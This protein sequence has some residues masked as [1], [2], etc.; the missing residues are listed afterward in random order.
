MRVYDNDPVYATLD[1]HLNLA[2][3]EETGKPM[4]TRAQV[5]ELRALFV[6]AKSKFIRAAGTI[7]L[8]MLGSFHASNHRETVYLTV[9]VDEK[10]SMLVSSFGLGWSDME[11][12]QQAL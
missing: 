8:G 5:T 10:R 1:I 2:Y 12:E 3:N 4:P 9:E 6:T 7:P 11:D